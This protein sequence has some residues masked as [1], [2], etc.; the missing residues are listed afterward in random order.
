M[1]LNTV[2]V[3]GGA[4]FIG[5]QLIKKLLPQCSQ[6][7]IID[8]LST[9]N[10][11]NI[12][13]SPKIIFIKSS[14]T[15]KYLLQKILPKVDYIFHLACSNLVKSVADMELDFHTNLYGQFTLL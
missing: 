5:S 1:N 11:N 15:D 9:G 2:L 7:Y 14:I 12:P 4:G 6:I 13:N 8:D 3:S 10:L